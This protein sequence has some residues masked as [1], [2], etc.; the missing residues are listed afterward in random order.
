MRLILALAGGIAA[1]TVAAP[2]SAATIIIYADPMTLERQTVIL[3]SAGPDRAF[4]CMKP[5]AVSG[6]QEIEVRRSRR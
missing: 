5:P 4:L 6:C 1:C 3:D 2:A